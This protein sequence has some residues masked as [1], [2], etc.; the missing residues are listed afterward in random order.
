MYKIGKSGGLFSR[1]LGPLL[2]TGLPLIKNLLKPL[3]ENVLIPV[4]VTAAA[5]A[6]DVATNKKMSR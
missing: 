3:V 1:P 6:K 4:G 5:L 2:K